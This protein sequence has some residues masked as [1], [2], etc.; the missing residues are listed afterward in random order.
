MSQ[1]RT[2]ERVA[3]IYED[4][5]SQL[6]DS[7]A[8]ATCEAIGARMAE[9]VALA[10]A[11][12]DRAGVTLAS[13]VT[14]APAMQRHAAQ[15]DVADAAAAYDAATALRAEGF[16]IWEPTTRAA[17]RVHAR[18]R[19]VLTLARTT[20][21][22]VALRLRWPATAWRL[23]RGLLPNQADFAVADLPSPL[24]P[25]YFVI[26]P[27]R[28]AAEKFGLRTPAPPVLGPFLSTPSDLIPELL[29][30]AQVDEH[31]TIAD[32]GCGDA[33]ILIDAARQTGCS[34]IGIESDPGLVA[35][36]IERSAAAGVSDRVQII[37]GDA[38]TA[39]LSQATAVFVFLPADATVR[40]VE[41]LLHRLA[42]GTR[43]IAH[44]QHPL[45]R[46][47]AGATSTALI[48]G[49]GVTVAHRWIVGQ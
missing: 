14:L 39:D 10:L 17:G 15:L 28:L 20:D 26:R 18:V 4:R 19:N 47:V 46:P 2:D 13:P 1:G 36:A 24:W 48:K 25:A 8:R 38:S 22:T 31:D 33:R 5:L 16:D 21:V 43:I 29:D 3:A 11:A 45:P 37:Q 23:P 49:Q 34:A 7:V 9:E 12:L 40:L 35:A 27:L 41:Q 30:L 6:D 44:E 42:P 32:L